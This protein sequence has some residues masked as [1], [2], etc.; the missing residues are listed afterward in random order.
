VTMACQEFYETFVA[1]QFKVIVASYPEKSPLRNSEYKVHE[2]KSKVAIALCTLTRKYGE[3]DIC[4]FSTPKK[5]ISNTNFAVGPCVLVPST[6]RYKVVGEGHDG[7]IFTCEG[8]GF[9]LE[10]MGAAVGMEAPAWFVNKTSSKKDG[11]MKVTHL[12][13]DVSV[14]APKP[15]ATHESMKISI[16]VLVNT[17]ALKKDTELKFFVQK[18]EDDA[19][20]SKKRAFDLI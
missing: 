20:M 19:T 17:K 3:P 9:S 1:Y 12:T 8:D 16:P 7:S 6:T 13:V 2:F 11:N 4:L 5:A 18:D 10:F 14:D 15:P